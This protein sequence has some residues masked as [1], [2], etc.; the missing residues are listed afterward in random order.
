MSSLEEAPAP[1]R[2]LRKDAARN[3]ELL[4]AAAREV[5]AERG[6]DASLDDVARRAGVGVGTA[7][8]HFA[9]KYELAGAIFQQ[10]VG[11]IAALAQAGLAAEDP[12]DGLVQ[13]LEEMLSAQTVNR[14]LREVLMGVHDDDLEDEVHDLLSG[15]IISLVVRAQE[16]GAVRAD[17][18]PTDLGMMIIMLCTVADVAAEADPQLWRRYLPILLAGLRPDG[19]G[20]PVPALNEDVMRKA[21]S[22]HKQRMARATGHR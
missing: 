6:L 7:Y 10:E 15:P 20:L 22:S 8:R 17:A 1:A 5:F 4:L 12:W 14:G 2:A 3:R 11:V 19:P 21:M 13:F 9:N 16:S 18:D